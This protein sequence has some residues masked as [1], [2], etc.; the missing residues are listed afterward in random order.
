MD[1]DEV[2][3]EAS[4]GHYIEA[5]VWDFSVMTSLSVNKCYVQR[6]KI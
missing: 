4:A 1:R 2:S 6:A 3:I 5:S